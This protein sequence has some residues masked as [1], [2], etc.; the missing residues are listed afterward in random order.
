MSKG[1]KIDHD[2]LPRKELIDVAT[3]VESVQLSDQAE[4]AYQNWFSQK[5]AQVMLGHVGEG[6]AYIFVNQFKSPSGKNR[7]NI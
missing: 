6:G 4:T 2:P 7:A 3:Y 1:L 5:L